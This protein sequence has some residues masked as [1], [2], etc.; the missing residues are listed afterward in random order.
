MTEHIN[1]LLDSI[2]SAQAWIHNTE[3]MQGA[4]GDI[5]NKNLVAIRRQL[6]KKKYAL[7][8]NPAIAI[9]GE[10][11]VG[12]SYLV[13]S[14][15]SEEGKP[16]SVID[17]KGNQYDFIDK[18]N[19]I[20]QGNESTGVVTRFSTNYKWINP[21]FPVK[22]KLHSPTDLILIL[23]DSFYNDLKI[24]ME[25]IL[26]EGEIN[27]EIIKLKNK[28]DGNEK[29]QNFI[30]E[31]QIRD[32]EDYFKTVFATKAVVLNNSVFFDDISRFIENVPVENWG[33]V[34]SILWN[35][36]KKLTQIFRDLVAYYQLIEFNR[37]VYVPIEAVLRE[38]GTLLDV[39]RIKELKSDYSGTEPKYIAT[40]SLFLENNNK[41]VE[42]FSKSHLSAMTAELVFALPEELNN[43]KPFLKKT[44]LLDFPGARS[45]M[46]I[47]ISKIEEETIPEML[48]RGKVAFLFT[49]YSNLDKIN[50]LLYC[51]FEQDT[52]T[53]SMSGML[54]EWVHNMVGKDV[55]ERTQTVELTEHSPL[56]LVST[57]F[58]KDLAFNKDTPEEFNLRDDRWNRRFKKSLA[59]GIVNTNI[60]KWFNNWTTNN[61]FQSIF[62]LRDF[63][64]SSEG[65]S[66]IYKGYKEF[67]IEKEEIKPENYP[68][69]RED[70]KQSFIN[71]DFV[72]K[73]FE[74]PELSWDSA[75]ALNQDG[76][77]LIID[78]LVITAENIIKSRNHK[79]KAE[80]NKLSEDL[81]LELHK[82]YHNSESD[83]ALQK[84]KSKAGK[85]QFN[86]NIA[87]A[88]DSHF[89]PFVLKELMLKEVEVYNL[90]IET[91][92]VVNKE[93]PADEE[94]IIFRNTIK[95]I[96]SD[97][98]YDENLDIVRKTY[99]FTS[100]EETEKMLVSRGIDIERLFYGQLELA[101]SRSKKLAIALENYWKDHYLNKD[102]ERLIDAFSAEGWED[103]REM[104]Y[105]LYKEQNISQK[106]ENK[107]RKFIDN[108]NNIDGSYEIIADIS[109]EIIN[110]FISTLGINNYPKEKWEE[111]KQANEK[112]NLELVFPI[113]KQQNITSKNEVAR[114]I[115][116]IGDLPNLMNQGLI[117]EEM[118]QMP[119]Y[120]NYTNWTNNVKIG[121]ISVCDI[122]NYDVNANEE[123]AKILNG[124]S[125]N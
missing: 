90:Y 100:L 87:F 5:T 17:G 21:D 66:N 43:T 73:H 121:F 34:F 60:N 41:T 124:F 94:L 99:N 30:F 13:G 2:K 23:C 115:T 51:H 11:Q 63:Y 53:N 28:Y 55:E 74:N 118:K 14:L 86:L 71:Y 108:Q 125:K 68:N 31:D 106:T 110:N 38:F 19:P 107:I 97:K 104:I 50:I 119:Y 54:S 18:I 32:I 47:E 93:L 8:E 39:Q 56:F 35:K 81:H 64:H 101:Y 120:R 61:S 4:K 57:M 62:L 98:K 27:D 12:K 84:A 96:S 1:I 33:E 85:I 37:E 111:L 76:S 79:F 7:E 65:Q 46:E 6:N 72:K 88:K 78:K 122:P 102:S 42:N 25:D 15:L 20:G 45:R 109:A 89:L 58:N 77:Q 75:A 114:L 116:N 83:E 22:A 113:N 26:T 52:K 10:S 29:V 24:S 40:T 92:K 49:N 69:F 123:L 67:Q 3:A 105:T 44:D 82:H 48:I 91:L 16:F 59:D 95:G 103:F 112:N 70:L 80:I 36:N 117:S 9:Y